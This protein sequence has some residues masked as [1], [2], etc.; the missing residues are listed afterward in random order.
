LEKRLYFEKKNATGKQIS[1]MHTNSKSP[2]NQHLNTKVRR[3]G[4]K[5]QKKASPKKKKVTTITLHHRRQGES[6]ATGGLS[7]G[8]KSWKRNTINSEPPT[9]EEKIGELVLGG[10]I[11]YPEVIEV[12]SGLG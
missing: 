5:N 8:K 12:N 6:G 2:G 10:R 3:S 7:K 11:L 9:P 1:G 4:K